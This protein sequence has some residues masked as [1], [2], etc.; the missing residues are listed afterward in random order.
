MRTKTSEIKHV[1]WRCG[2]IDYCS[3]SSV[4]FNLTM[5][6]FCTGNL[7]NSRQQ[8]SFF[9]V[10][11]EERSLTIKAGLLLFDQGSSSF[12]VL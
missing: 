2:A 5:P 9:Y 12:S 11:K 7:L 1:Q 10:V 6:M 8:K 3:C 4:S